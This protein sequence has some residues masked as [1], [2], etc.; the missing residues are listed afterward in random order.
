M[1]V[2]YEMICYGLEICDLYLP[3]RLS[4]KSLPVEILP[5]DMKDEGIIFS[6]ISRNQ[7]PELT[8]LGEID[9]FNLLQLDCKS[10]S[11]MIETRD[12]CLGIYK[13]LNHLLNEANSQA[14]YTLFMEEQ[15][16][17]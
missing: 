16:D 13:R 3:E 6:I 17:Y 15:P 10:N 9:I 1:T 12:E 7:F 4:S 14:N 5:K 8:E 11:Y 2:E